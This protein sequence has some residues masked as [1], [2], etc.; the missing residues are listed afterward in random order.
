MGSQF[1]A[2]HFFAVADNK[3]I[4]NENRV[5]PGLA[6]NRLKAIEFAV[7]LRFGGDANN[8]TLLGQT[9]FVDLW[10]QQLAKSITTAFP[11]PLPLGQID[12]AK[13][14]IIQFVDIIA[15]NCEIV[16]RGL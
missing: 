8:F 10:Q 16:E 1:K 11:K 14:P 15:M 9:L 3:S 7:F 6:I 5:V 4:A 2:R 12:T 13:I